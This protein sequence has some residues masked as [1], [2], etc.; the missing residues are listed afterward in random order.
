MMKNVHVMVAFVSQLTQKPVNVEYRSVDGK[1]TFSCMQTNEAAVCQLQSLLGREG[2]L[3]KIVLIETDQ[4]REK[5]QRDTADWLALMEK[6]GSE[7]MSAVELLKAQS[8]RKYPKLSQ[9]FED[10]EYS[11]M[12]IEDS[13]RSI[14]GIAE[15][16]RAFAERVREE[17]PEAEVVLHAD[18]TGGFRY[19]A[20]MLLVVMQLSKYMGIRM[21]HVVYS[22]LVRGGESRVHL[23]DDIRHMFDLVAGAD[24]FQ[25]YGSVQALEEYFSRS[26]R[27]S[28]DFSTLF[29]AMRR[30]SDAI[31]ICRTSV[32]EDEM[33][34]LAEK[35]RAF[36]QSKPASIEEE[37]FSHI[38]GVIEGEYG[39]VIKNAS[40][41]KSARRLDI[42]AWCVQK[43]FLQQAMTLCTEWI[44]AI[45]VEKKICYTEDEEVIR[46]CRDNGKPAFQNWQQQFVNVYGSDKK[47][48]EKDTSPRLFPKGN[49]AKMVRYILQQ[50]D[51]TRIEDLPKEVRAK[52]IAFFA[53]YEKDYAKRCDF[54][55]RKDIRLCIRDFAGKYPMLNK[56][57]HILTE[58][59]KKP[60]FYSALPYR[61]GNLPNEK[62]FDFFSIA[63]EEAEKYD[64]QF[65]DQSDSEA[66][67]Q[68]RWERREKQYR[69][70]LA[71][72]H[73]AE[74]MHTTK[75]ADEAIEFLRGY[76]RIRNERNYSNHAVKDA[77]QGNE[78]LESFIA[79]YI[80]KL[81][82]A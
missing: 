52:L 30:F 56:A 82:K 3:A 40:G 41:E 51:K 18:M 63:S 71:G 12:G 15:R 43:K 70:M 65:L 46:Q 66:S 29:A 78:S 23:T 31:R 11:K 48:G 64:A 21:G 1:E 62:L 33:T 34:D 79:A 55:L 72:K 4:A 53:E 6:Y 73:G 28:E 37:M 61:L 19:A 26:P 80:E 20:M 27:H 68:E 44:P 39:S 2:G 35:I 77:A 10:I 9:V 8:A 14:A 49:L 7:S 24:E 74:V 22:D 13:M 32:I 60:F 50:K 16:V 54:D 81:R 42:I 76:F 38:L 47:K 57:V 25:K 67:Q 45:L 17:D 75:P 69:S 36:R 58:T 5:V 59:V